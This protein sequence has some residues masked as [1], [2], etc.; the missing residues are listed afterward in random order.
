[1]LTINGQNAP[2]F[3][4]KNLAEYLAVQGY[5]VTRLAVERNGDI[6]PKAQYA[7]TLLQDGDV[8]EIVRF[9]GGG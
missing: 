3:V 6:V 1:M 8:V 2:D 5:E 7:Q 4:G 9:V